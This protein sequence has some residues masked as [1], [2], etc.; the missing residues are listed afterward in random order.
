MKRRSRFLAG[1]LSVAM[2]MTSFSVPVTAAELEEDVLPQIETTQDA[3][4]VAES[5]EALG[6]EEDVIA[7]ADDEEAAEAEAVA[8]EAEEDVAGMVGDPTKGDTLV[9]VHSYAE[10]VKAIEGAQAGAQVTIEARDPYNLEND[11]KYTVSANTLLTIPAGKD[12]KLEVFADD[13]L[14]FDTE[15]IDKLRTDGATM[16]KYPKATLTVESGAKLTVE[17]WDDFATNVCVVNNGEFTA[18][19]V[20]GD[21][22]IV[23]YNGVPFTNEQGATAKLLNGSYVSSDGES[24]SIINN[25]T[26]ITD[27]IYAAADD[28]KALGADR[29][30]VV[31]KGEMIMEDSTVDNA[32]YYYEDKEGETVYRFGYAV[33]NDKEAKLAVRGEADLES[34]YNNGTLTVGSE[35]DFQ[36]NVGTLYALNESSTVIHN[37]EINYVD[38]ATD[39]A[40]KAI[41][42]S[43]TVTQVGGEI[44]ALRFADVL[45]ILD[46]GI[47]NKLIHAVF[48]AEAKAV[49]DDE[50]PT[51]L[52]FQGYTVE[53]PA[54]VEKKP[55]FRVYDEAKDKDTGYNVE[56]KEVKYLVAT[57]IENGVPYY[58][59][60]ILDIDKVPT[61]EERYVPNVLYPISSLDD[62][63]K[64]AVSENAAGYYLTQDIEVTET[65]TFKCPDIYIDGYYTPTDAD[66]NPLLDEEEKEIEYSGDLVFTGAGAFVVEEGAVVDLYQVD[67]DA[68]TSDKEKAPT[69]TLFTNK[70]T[71]Y[72]GEVEIRYNTKPVVENSGTYYSE[73]EIYA[74]DSEATLIV[75]TENA[76]AYLNADME[77]EDAVKGSLIDNAGTMALATPTYQSDLVEFGL[78]PGAD[79]EGK[80]ITGIT[81]IK[82][83]G[84]MT[85]TDVYVYSTVPDSVVVDNLGSLSL[86]EYSE[87]VDFSGHMTIA[88]YAKGTTA[89]LNNGANASF[90]MNG[91][92]V[93]AYK[94]D[95][96]DEK[97][98]AVSYAIVYTDNEPVLIRGSVYGSRGTTNHVLHKFDAEGNITE[99]LEAAVCGSAVAKKDGTTGSFKDSEAQGAL[100]IDS[101]NAGVI[102]DGQIPY[103]TR[104]AVNDGYGYLLMEKGE[105]VVYSTANDLHEAAAFS[106]TLSKNTF[107]LPVD[108]M[109]EYVS[110][111][112]AVANIKEV[113]AAVYDPENYNDET[114][115]GLKDT[116]VKVIEAVGTGM[117]TIRVKSKLAG[118]EDYLVIE[119]VAKGM[120]EKLV[121]DSY[122]VNLS[123]PFITMNALQKYAR[124]GIDW[125]IKNYESATGSYDLSNNFYP[126]GVIVRGANGEVDSDFYKYF[127]VYDALMKDGTTKTYWAMLAT[128]T[129]GFQNDNTRLAQDGTTALDNINVALVVQNKVSKKTFEVNANQKLS[130]KIDQ[131]VPVIKLSKGAVNAAY[132]ESHNYSSPSVIDINDQEIYRGEWGEISTISLTDDVKDFESI[133]DTRITYIGSAKGGS[134]KVPMWIRLRDYYGKYYAQFNVRAKAVYPKV[135]LV[136]KKATV[137]P[138]AGDYTN[139]DVFVK[140]GKEAYD[141]NAI[142]YAEIVDNDKFGIERVD[143]DQFQLIPRAR[144]DKSE[145]VTI[146]LNYEGLKKNK[147]KTYSTL[148]K[149]SVKAVDPSKLKLSKPF[150]SPLYVR[151]EEVK[152]G[153]NTTKVINTTQCGRIYWDV[154]PV[155]VD[156][157]NLY[158]V[159]TSL[160]GKSYATSEYGDDFFNGVT[161]DKE[162]CIY[163]TDQLTD[164][165]KFVS[166]KVSM[167]DSSNTKIGK[168]AVV[169]VPVNAGECKVNEPKAITIDLTKQSTYNSSILT[170]AKGNIRVLSS[171][172]LEYESYFPKA[173]GPNDYLDGWFEVFAANSTAL[174]AENG[175]I[176]THVDYKGSPYFYIVT[177]DK[178]IYAVTD[179]DALAAGLIKPGSS[180]TLDLTFESP[181]GS[182]VVPLTINIAGIK[183]VKAS[184]KAFTDLSGITSYA[185]A[186]IGIQTEVPYYGLKIQSVTCD[187]PEFEI[188]PFTSYEAIGSDSPKF[189][190]D[191]GSSTTATG[192][193]IAQPNYSYEHSDG[194]RYNYYFLTWKDNKPS[195]AKN[196]VVKVNLT[197]TYTCGVTAKV[198]VPVNVYGVAG[199]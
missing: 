65:V 20:D 173:I 164:K 119:S 139:I 76:Q 11:D 120:R 42:K 188:S 92:N 176:L 32:A 107:G 102:V 94:Y 100:S 14:Q 126:V 125:H 186:G 177:D 136:N 105:S 3:E 115:S 85:M 155:D 130:F 138:E 178:K 154:L 169:K 29:F 53:G 170:K 97:D 174:K 30:S 147:G 2:V 192:E 80:P 103:T 88:P 9:M 198:T 81:A 146:K 39:K 79:G 135:S 149:F 194:L 128:N 90:V 74:E 46:R 112:P 93:N 195:A 45:P 156:V 69:A 83:S 34:I 4:E 51:T 171:D 16:D 145:K 106:L 167:Y 101:M 131:K 22:V 95:N 59:G 67:V 153:E 110:N 21:L 17:A 187:S 175:A 37:A 7:D 114:N 172:G 73:D 24:A 168:D 98:K 26:L 63:K 64:A 25:G 142:S 60:A 55:A 58:N 118:N 108:D 35:N 82:N 117:A 56:Y 8:D 185:R 40:G 196:G 132:L 129:T 189:D 123:T 148:L 50:D 87:D 5:V 86:S 10:L 43:G 28:T 13:F 152:E 184:G 166:V 191:E 44:G 183:K 144:I 75:N 104:V 57:S 84:T 52:Y 199:K 68:Y 27:S 48:D 109:F 18:D 181:N 49:V 78:N 31:N 157:T 33:L 41:I 70:G 150:F 23:P 122:E 140:P 36:T 134:Y 1:L 180:Y 15:E 124:I 151:S 72:T 137:I 66:G 143:T 182:T 38:M 113:T 165:D 71:L 158:F 190:A 62:L 197:V 133:S 162:A 163:A 111:D 116:K 160:D 96:N 179:S 99:E 6:A 91:G 19:E 159:V 141:L 127:D 61:R 89:V 54:L 77:S 193:G 47:T 12:I 121:A 161:T